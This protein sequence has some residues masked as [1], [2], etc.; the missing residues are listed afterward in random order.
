MQRFLDLSNLCEKAA[1]ECS[2]YEQSLLLKIPTKHNRFEPGSIF[3]PANF[4]YEIN[5]IL[6]EMKVIFKIIDTLKLNQDIG[7]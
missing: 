6:R 7:L 5:T 2:F 3:T 1:I 4:S